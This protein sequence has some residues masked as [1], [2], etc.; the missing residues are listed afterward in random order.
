MVP[1]MLNLS[2]YGDESAIFPEKGIGDFG[3]MSVIGFSIKIIAKV[4]LKGLF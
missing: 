3:P 4:T 2:K 1:I